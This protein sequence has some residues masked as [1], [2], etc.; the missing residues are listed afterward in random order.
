MENYVVASVS[1]SLPFS[2]KK[3]SYILISLLL[4][5]DSLDKFCKSIITYFTENYSPI[6]RHPTIAQ[7][8]ITGPQHGS[9]STRTSCTR[10]H[11]KW[12]HVCYNQICKMCVKLAIELTNSK[13]KLSS[14]M[15]LYLMIHV[16]DFKGCVCVCKRKTERENFLQ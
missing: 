10:L 4:T 2:M 15:F 11:V 16:H 6:P 3:H 9:I 8:D 14:C 1:L 13:V 5:G 12:F 7:Q